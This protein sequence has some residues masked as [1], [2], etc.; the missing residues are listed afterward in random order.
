MSPTRSSPPSSPA[1]RPQR[2]VPHGFL[3]S[4]RPKERAISE[5]GIR[6]LRQRHVRNVKRLEESGPSSST[7]VQRINAEQAAIERRLV[8][9]GVDD[10]QRKL[11]DTSLHEEDTM[12]IDNQPPPEP[13][14]IGA[15][16]R[17]LAKFSASIHQTNPTKPGDVFTFQE[18]MEIEAAAHR[19]EMQRKKEHEERQEER[20]RRMGLPQK[21]DRALSREE[22]DARIWAFMNYKPTESDLEDEDDEDD[23]DEDPSGWFED[24]QDDGR[25]GQDIIEPDFDDY[26][27]IIRID[28]GRIP[29]NNFFEGE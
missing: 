1:G 29:R 9:L 21:E 11:N 15:K 23:E 28:E 17:A 8:E 25:K 18:A 22:Q 10:I 13:R 20:R 27:S 16:Q 2:S 6:E 24:D 7:Y 5:L 3:P 12:N 19:A 26:S 4:P 14:P